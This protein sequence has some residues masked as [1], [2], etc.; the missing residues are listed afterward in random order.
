[1]RAPLHASDAHLAACQVTAANLRTIALLKHSLLGSAGTI[2][3]NPSDSQLK[4]H[5]EPI[6]QHWQ[7]NLAEHI[8]SKLTDTPL[9]LVLNISTTDP[10]RGSEALSR[11]RDPRRSHGSEAI[12]DS[13]CSLGSEDPQSETLS[14][15]QGSE[16]LS[17]IRGSLS[18]PQSEA[19]S[20]IRGILSDTRSSATMRRVTTIPTWRSS[21]RP[22]SSN[23]KRS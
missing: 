18:D 14:R 23:T 15:I 12:R 19:L 8:E 22:L 9:T 3:D 21:C 1:V 5:Q 2:N 13:M 10:N 20:R 4:A 11:I 16:A 6:L 17:W 7:G